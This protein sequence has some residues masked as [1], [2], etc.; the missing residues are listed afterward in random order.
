ME[1]TKNAL[2]ISDQIAALQKRGLV[3]RDLSA[4][5]QSLNNVTYIVYWLNNIDQKNTFVADLKIILSKFPT[6]NPGAMGFPQ[7]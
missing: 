4:I 2:S 6:I 5:E 1:Y 3:V 7:G